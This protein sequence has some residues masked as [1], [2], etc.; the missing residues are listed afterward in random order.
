M[1]A[2]Q[3][4]EYAILM[5]HVCVRADTRPAYWPPN[6]AWQQLRAVFLA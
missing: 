1:H 4:T 2:R 5:V 3:V 6:F